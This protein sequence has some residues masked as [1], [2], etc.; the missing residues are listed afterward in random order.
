MP[1]PEL[2]RAVAV[3][4]LIHAD[5][6][7]LADVAATEARERLRQHIGALQSYID[8]LD[9]LGASTLYASDLAL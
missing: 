7:I 5:F 3:L 9:G 6:P 8:T 1:L 4:S 2:R